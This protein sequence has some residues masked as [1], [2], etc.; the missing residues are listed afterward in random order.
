MPAK[1][2]MLPSAEPLA[3]VQRFDAV[4][5]R[6]GFAAR[7]RLDG[8]ESFDEAT[9]CARHMGLV[10]IAFERLV[11]GYVVGRITAN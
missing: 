9:R 4:V 7:V 3:L 8:A 2:Q 6:E 10:P 1:R 5:R 11:D